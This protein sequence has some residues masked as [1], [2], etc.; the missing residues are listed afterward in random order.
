MSDE[1]KALALV[2]RTVRTMSSS[3]PDSVRRNL[4]RAWQL[5]TDS[6]DVLG[7]VVFTLADI[8]ELE[9]AMNI[10]HEAIQIHGETVNVLQ[11]IGKIALK[12]QDYAVAEKVFT[13]L[14]QLEAGNIE[15]YISLID[16]M[17]T[18]E[19][20]AEAV[21]LAKELVS[22]FPEDASAWNA[23]GSL[24]RNEIYDEGSAREF[25]KQAVR[26]DR[27]NPIYL[28]NLSSCF[29]SVPDKE[30][31]N[32]KKAL[33][34]S[35]GNAQ[36]HLTLGISLLNQGRV[37]EA[38]EHYNYRKDP[39][40]GVNKASQFSHPYK[41]WAGEDLSG[42]TVVVCA[43][44]GL[45]DEVFF[46]IAL[47]KA[48]SAAKTILVVC[49]P[50][51]VD[52]VERSF[53]NVRA[54]PFE[55]TLQY[56]IRCRRFPELDAYVKARTLNVDYFTLFGDLMR[57][58]CRTNKQFG[59][60]E[61]GYFLPDN[62]LLK[63][64][65]DRLNHNNDRLKIGFSWRSGNIKNERK[66]F[67]QSVDFYIELAKRVDADFYALQY[68]ISDQERAELEKIENITLFD[69]IDLKNDIEANLA[70]MA[71]LDL[72][73]GPPIA[74]QCFA[75]AAGRPIWL[76]NQGKPWY[77]L[78]VDEMPPFFAEGSQW[79]C[80]DIYKKQPEK[81]LD[82]VTNSLKDFGVQGHA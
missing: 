47:K 53:A 11:L 41:E 34:F 12:M 25:F 74:T 65:Q 23:L 50:R 72:V 21:E 4:L 20:G 56:G 63:T 42:K 82:L 17:H 76:F 2:A 62:V 51:L 73:M 45:G 55:D 71:N 48:C 7:A 27:S 43:E 19:R 37:D 16:C 69:D 30:E 66:F 24:A 75:L 39:K 58:A 6:E 9:S 1:K 22:A 70:L 15:H 67:Y 35:P 46:L 18:Q 32:L 26:L 79:W 10:L 59:D 49:D 3:S 64:Y 54:F 31:F 78:G 40:L 52:I 14:V 8:S 80:L 29:S 5:A 57:Y 44:Q 38:W 68:H 77:F 33:M 28:Y 36:M 81:L 60:L 13:R 61:G